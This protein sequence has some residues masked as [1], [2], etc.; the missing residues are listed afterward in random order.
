M[1]ELPKISDKTDLTMDEA[2]EEYIRLRKILNQTEGFPDN[3]TG[4]A[5]WF[6]N[7]IN[8][9]MNYLRQVITDAVCYEP[10]EAEIKAEAENDKENDKI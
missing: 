1:V 2:A 3:G 9:R 7:K 4:W 10:T 6:L 8:D 5:G